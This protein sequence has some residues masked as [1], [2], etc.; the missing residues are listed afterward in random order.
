MCFAWWPGRVSTSDCWGKIL[1]RKCSNSDFCLA[2][3]EERTTAAIPWTLQ[4]ALLYI[5][6]WKPQLSVWRL[7]GIHKSEWYSCKEAN[8][9]DKQS[10]QFKR[11]A[12]Q[13]SMQHLCEKL[14]V[15]VPC[16]YFFFLSICRSIAE[17]KQ[18]K[19]AQ[20]IKDKC[21]LPYDPLKK[22]REVD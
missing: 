2:L 8:G 5:P 21:K 19:T 6:N 1:H 9:S 12:L 13:L 15:S 18:W 20:E 4:P 16:T 10:L 14:V 17:N 7:T 11:T 22:L 3:G